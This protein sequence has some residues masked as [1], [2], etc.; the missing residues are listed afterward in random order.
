MGHQTTADH[1]HHEHI[2]PLFYSARK[3]EIGVAFK[4]LGLGWKDFKAAWRVSLAYGV[5]LVAVAYLLLWLVMDGG[6]TFVLFT[7]GM[8]LILMGPLLAFGVYSISR[9][10][11]LGLVPK[12]GYCIK[13]SRSHLRNEL[14]FALVMLVIMLVWARAASMVHVFFPISE[15][16]SFMGWVQF[17]SVGSA[18]GSIF[19]SLIF[20]ASAFALPMMLASNKDAITSVLTSVGAVLTNKSAMAVWAVTIVMLMLLGIATGLLGL[21]VVLPLIGHAT[22]HAYRDAIQIEENVTE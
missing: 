4:W 3:L 7:L 13:D 17:L 10:L 16:I 20:M 8:G 14:L 6:N 11:E 21:A 19:A 18:V 12:L 2:E 9:Q 15:D 1:E 22:W 5:S